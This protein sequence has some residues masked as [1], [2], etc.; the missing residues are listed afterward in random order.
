MRTIEL[1]EDQM[2]HDGEDK[3]VQFLDWKDGPNTV[4]E[5]VDELLAA[6][7]LEIVKIETHADDYLFR[8]EKREA[9]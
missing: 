5:A 1:P 9:A 7:G 8:I 6:H 4:L 3:T 2:P